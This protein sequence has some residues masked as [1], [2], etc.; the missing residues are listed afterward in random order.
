M[1]PNETKALATI[2][3]TFDVARLRQIMRNAHDR[4]EA[5]EKAAFNKL[6]SVSAGAESEDP[7]ARECWEMVFAIEEL[8]RIAGRKVWR[9]NRLRPTIE[10]KG[11]VAALEYC[12]LNETDGFEEVLAYGRADLL[13]ES[14]VLRH[15]DRFSSDAI[16]AAQRRL[17]RAKADNRSAGIP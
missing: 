12:A 14:I 5:V 17:E 13:A 15:Q 1:T 4:S 10:E 11:V 7:L 16:E 6:V 2:D 3:K 9:M 8:R